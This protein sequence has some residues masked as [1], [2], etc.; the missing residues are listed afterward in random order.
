MKPKKIVTIFS[1]LCVV[2]LCVQVGEEQTQ[3]CSDYVPLF[4]YMCL[5]Y[6]A[7]WFLLV[8][9]AMFKC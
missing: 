4:K 3:Y 1:N 6:S 2:L 7:I 8:C 5:L 9:M